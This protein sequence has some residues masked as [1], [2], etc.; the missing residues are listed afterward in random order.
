MVF[1]HQNFKDDLKTLRPDLQTKF[2]FKVDEIDDL[3][4]E[5]I[6]EKLKEIFTHDSDVYNGLSS[7]RLTSDSWQDYPI[8]S[9]LNNVVSI[10]DSFI[11]MK[12]WLFR[13]T[14]LTDLIN[15]I[16]QESTEAELFKP[17]KV[18]RV[19]ASDKLRTLG[20]TW[21][22]EYIWRHYKIITYNKDELPEWI[23]DSLIA[24]GSDRR[25]KRVYVQDA[26]DNWY[27]IHQCVLV[28]TSIK[29]LFAHER[30]NLLEKII[31][32]LQDNAKYKID[33][34]SSI[35]S[36]KLR[37]FMEI[38]KSLEQHMVSD[39]TEEAERILAIQMDVK[40]VLIKNEQITDVKYILGTELIVETVPLFCWD[41]KLPIGRY[42]ITIPLKEW[43]PI[44]INLDIWRGNWY[45]HPHVQSNWLCCL[46]EYVSPMRESYNKQDF[47]TLV[48]F[49]IEFLESLNDRSVFQSM[50]TRQD[51]HY[52]KFIQYLDKQ[53][54]VSKAK[55]NGETPNIIIIDDPD[56]TDIA[57]NPDQVLTIDWTTD[58]PARTTATFAENPIVDHAELQEVD[59]QETSLA[60]E[61]SDRID[62]EQDEQMQDEEHPENDDAY[63]EANTPATF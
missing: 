10:D 23:I 26:Y 33:E 28:P 34:L 40:N 59:L 19:C 3:P 42:K 36:E 4:N 39:F 38:S 49:F 56:I 2:T 8:T 62:R 32:D 15:T 50:T 30:K 1:I 43:N 61:D 37:E 58:V 57:A 14:G 25:H 24:I 17:W 46:G 60:Q 44:A 11:R 29:D 47:I 52:K 51:T 45:Q 20:V 13:R 18:C 53:P 54:K 6:I 12:E 7:R 41:A 5:K 35:Y 16:E 9:I 21:L 22:R 48:G 31:Y 63:A 55:A 27:S